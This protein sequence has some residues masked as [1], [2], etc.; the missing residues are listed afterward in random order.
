M[1]KFFLSFFPRIFELIWEG[2]WLET[3]EGYKCWG[4]MIPNYEAMGFV[5]AMIANAADNHGDE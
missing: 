4:E 3:M 1:F 5:W 2:G